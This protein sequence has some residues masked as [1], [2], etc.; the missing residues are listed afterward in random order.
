MTTEDPQPIEDVPSDTIVHPLALKAQYLMDHLSI[1]VYME[2]EFTDLGIPATKLNTVEFDNDSLTIYVPDYIAN[3]NVNYVNLARLVMMGKK[4]FLFEQIADSC[5]IDET[6]ILACKHFVP[7]DQ[8]VKS[9]GSQIPRRWKYTVAPLKPTCIH[10]S[11]MDQL[12]SPCNQ[13]PLV[14]QCR[15]YEAADWEPMKAIALKDDS[16]PVR[17][18]VRYMVPRTPQYRVVTPSDTIPFDALSEAEKYYEAATSSF[19][20]VIDLSYETGV[21]SHTHYIPVA[22]KV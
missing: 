14:N 3:I 13:L 4:Q 17:L 7:S 5:A 10:P 18:E 20:E 9:F 21:G 11:I 6:R 8:M 1:T 16:L 15:M 12:R 19:S 2:S 22:T